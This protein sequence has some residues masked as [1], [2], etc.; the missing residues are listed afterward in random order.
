MSHNYQYDFDWNYDADEPK[1]ERLF[2]LF[3]AVF[4][5]NESDLKALY[6]SGFANPTYTPF[7]YF[8]DGIA[9]ANVSMFELPMRIGG[10]RVNAAGIQSVMT[11]PGHRGRGLF[12]QLF[13]TMLA[14][15]DRRHEA[16]FLFTDSPRLYEGF[17]FRKVEETFFVS[18]YRYRPGGPSTRSIRSLRKLSLASVEDLQVI[19]EQFRQNTP[20]SS[21]FAPM[22]H[23]ASFYLNMF[24]PQLQSNLYYSEQLNVL[25]VFE[26]EGETLKLYDI[27][28]RRIPKL[29]EVAAA[30]GEP[31]SK[32]ECYFHPDLLHPGPWTPIPSPGHLMVRGAIELPKQIHF[33]IT[34]AF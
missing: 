30:I 13:E 16:S 8:H 22:S 6:A 19:Q 12:R 21:V 31:V 27:V 18:P 3:Q 29:D 4:N 26:F 24:D 11:D 15:L 20:V 25:I 1:R 32:V 9:V 17:G 23:G 14:E 34:A 2:P 7:T 28:G 10:R 5:L 33:P